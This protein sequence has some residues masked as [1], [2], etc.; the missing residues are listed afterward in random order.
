[1]K[2][3]SKEAFGDEIRRLIQAN[4]QLAQDKQNSDVIRVVIEAD[5]NQL[6]SEKNA[7]VAKYEEL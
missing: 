6:I 4:I 1:M 7:L 2:T 3:Y 5:K